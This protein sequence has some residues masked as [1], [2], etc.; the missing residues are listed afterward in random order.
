MQFIALSTAM[1]LTAC[2]TPAP[3]LPISAQIRA[4]TPS[5]EVVAPIAQSEIYVEVPQAQG[6]ASYGLIGAL[7]DVGVDA[8]R[9]SNA[10]AAVKPLRDAAIDYSFDDVLRGELQKS[11]S[12]VAWLHLDRVRV[13][14][15]V[16]NDA[17]SKNITGSPDGAIV[18][19]GVNYHLSNNA[20]TVYVIVNLAMFGN[21]EALKP[22][23]PTDAKTDKAS[24]LSNAIYRNSY[25]FM[26]R[27]P[28]ASGDRKLNM[29]SWSAN[30]G[31][32]FRMAMSLGAAKL[33]QVMAADLQGLEEPT[34]PPQPGAETV[35]S[36]DGLVIM[37]DADGSLL[38]HSDGSL[39]Y[40]A[41]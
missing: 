7:V 8:V 21:S 13:V 22:F 14:K 35:A 25:M 20:D 1:A 19:V 17:M 4:A 15:D 27:A 32:P 26:A 37:K 18:T 5:T 12:N 16:S 2:A 28:A 6:G 38:R 33:S 36:N 11:L 9:T 10:E 34:A 29:A 41:K 23:R 31:A 40:T 39:V 30:N 24:D 3:H